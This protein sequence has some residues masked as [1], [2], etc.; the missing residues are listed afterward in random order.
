MIERLDGREIGRKRR[1]LV[2]VWRSIDPGWGIVVG[3]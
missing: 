3:W 1:Y 2:V